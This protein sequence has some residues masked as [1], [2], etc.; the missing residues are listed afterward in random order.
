[1]KSSSLSIRLEKMARSG[2]HFLW[3]RGTCSHGGNEKLLSLYVKKPIDAR[4]LPIVSPTT[5]QCDR[6]WEVKVLKEFFQIVLCLNSSKEINLVTVYIR[7]F[8][9][10]LP[11]VMRPVDKPSDLVTLIMATGGEGVRIT[12]RLQC[13]IDLL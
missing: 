9:S 1:M 6:R 10:I 12:A 5:Q 11:I 2:H 7:V 13:P 8:F 4:T 3:F